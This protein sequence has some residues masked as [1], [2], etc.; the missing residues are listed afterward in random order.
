MLFGD[1]PGMQK[2][3][4][5]VSCP[6]FFTRLEAISQSLCVLLFFSEDCRQPN[7]T[8][9]IREAAPLHPL[10]LAAITGPN[11]GMPF[12]LLGTPWG[13]DEARPHLSP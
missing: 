1:S 9:F 2:W 8:P 4:L 11:S 5:F 3:I 6:I 10:L 12:V 7:R 13:R